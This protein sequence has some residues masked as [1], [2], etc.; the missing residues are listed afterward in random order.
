MSKSGLVALEGLSLISVFS[1]QTRA[2][3]AVKLTDSTNEQPL[4]TFIAMVIH[5]TL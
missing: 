1:S 3:A 2:G 5:S 4:K